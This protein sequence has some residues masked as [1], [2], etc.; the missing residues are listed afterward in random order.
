[1]KLTEKRVAWIKALLEEAVD[2]ANDFLDHTDKYPDDIVVN[3]DHGCSLDADGICFEVS[4][5]KTAS[6]GCCS[7]FDDIW[8]SV[9]WKYVYDPYGWLAEEEER[10]AK[11]LQDKLRQRAIA[12]KMAEQ[13]TKEREQ[14]RLAELI[15]K[16]PDLAQDLLKCEG[17]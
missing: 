14:N 13:R 12:D 3:S 16:Y 15:Q 5:F 10:K 7:D 8:V 9:P 17:V 11:E 4:Y 2:I 6:C 1:M